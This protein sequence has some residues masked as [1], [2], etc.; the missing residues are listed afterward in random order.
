MCLGENMD[1]GRVNIGAIKFENVRSRPVL[2]YRKEIGKFLE[3][4]ELCII[5]VSG[6]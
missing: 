2:D 4:H 1:P 3:Q 6:H 5:C